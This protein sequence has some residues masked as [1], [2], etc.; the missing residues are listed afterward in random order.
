MASD[1]DIARLRRMTDLSDE[2]SVYTDQLLGAMIDELT[3]EAA[4]ASVWREK[5]ASYAALVDTTESGS[6]RRLSQLHDQAV[7]MAGVVGPVTE[8][9]TKGGSFTVGIERV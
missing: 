2:D 3:F 4:A 5:A 1:S 8:E 7:R 6:S 9:V